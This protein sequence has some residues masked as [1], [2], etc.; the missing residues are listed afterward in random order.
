MSGDSETVMTA[1]EDKSWRSDHA[2]D[3]RYRL[4]WL[5]GAVYLRVILGRERRPKGRSR[6][7]IAA[8]VRKS[9]LNILI[10]TML[11]IL[12]YT[13]VITAVLMMSSVLI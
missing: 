7:E 13:G 12:V 9:L 2:V 5:G 1:S 10:F 4:P 11:A 8:S 6:S 3:A